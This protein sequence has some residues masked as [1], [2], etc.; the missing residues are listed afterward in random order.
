MLKPVNK[1]TQA[2]HTI[3]AGAAT[4][5]GIIYLSLHLGKCWD[6]TP[7]S[8]DAVMIHAL[9]RP[10]DV[11]PINMQYL[12]IGVLA[13][14]ISMLLIYQHYLNNRN[15]RPDEESGSASWNEDLKAYYKKYADVTKGTNKINEDTGGNHTWTYKEDDEGHKIYKHQGT[16][17][18]ILSQDVVLSMDTRKTRRN[19]NILVIGGSGTGK[20]RY[21]MKPNMLQANTSFVITDPSGELLESMGSFLQEKG[22]EIKGL[23]SL[24]EG[25]R[26]FH[27]GTSFKD[28]QFYTSGGRVLMVVGFGAD[29]QEA[30]DKALAAVESIECDNLFYRRDIGW[31]VL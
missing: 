8:I 25:I 20:S 24:P 14:L 30:H 26:V 17:N 28:G 6:G 13:A 21:V 1:K 7:E 31:R 23:E 29:L 2:R 12:G 11:F 18:M 22:Y 9:T 3:Y 15:L 27:M 5:I 16:K 10:W 4:G 19:N